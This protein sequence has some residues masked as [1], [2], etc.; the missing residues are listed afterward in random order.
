MEK[1][2]DL[3]VFIGR[4][5]PFHNEH[6]R[7]IDIAL[8]RSRNVLVL[9]GSA[10]KARSV[11]NPFTFQE[12]KRMIAANYPSRFYGEGSEWSVKD[13]SLVIRPL[14][15]K[16][17]NESAW[18]KQVQDI[19]TGVA[20]DIANP[21]DNDKIFHANGISGLKIGLI[22]TS[23]DHTSY[24]LNLFPQWQKNSV[25]VPLREE[26]HA[27]DLRNMFFEEPASFAEA[28]NKSPTPRHRVMDYLMNWVPMSVTKF[29]YEEYFLGDGQSAGGFRDTAYYDQ[30]VKELAF[31]RN[32]KKQWEAAPYPVKHATVDAVVEQSGHVLVVR[33]KSEPGKGLWALPGGHLN[34]FETQ[35][36]GCIRELREE[37]KLKVPDP[38]LKGSIVAE[39]TFD[40][41]HRSQ[42][43]RVI[44][45]AYHIRLAPAAELPKV[46]GADDAE[47]ARWL[48]ISEVAEDMFFDDHYHIIQ[49]FL[50][51]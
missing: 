20:L 6:K 42:I 15:D 10:G 35:L 22:G 12:R 51:L 19:V 48:P 49:H 47:K 23:K 2:F 24:Y 5:Q 46:K 31:V 43:G 50:G 36:D 45:Q 38:V 41:P 37:T 40:D 25:D 39:K 3:L 1:E 27:T 11:R 33:R 8:E 21:S 4:F 7:I 30:L 17:Y 34:E 9:I 18:V 32:Y 26:L 13:T 29:L 14:F 28:Y 44:T 16:T